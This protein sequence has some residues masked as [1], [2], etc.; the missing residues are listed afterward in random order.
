MAFKMKNNSMA[1]MARE[2]GA[3]RPSA[4]KKIVVEG[5]KAAKKAEREAKREARKAAKQEKKDLKAVGGDQ[6]K[7][8]K[9]RAQQ[10]ERDRKRE[11]YRID[12]REALARQGKG[13]S[14]RDE[15]GSTNYVRATRGGTSE[16]EQGAVSR[17]AAM[18]RNPLELKKKTVKKA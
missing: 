12:N 18:A 9:K 8:D 7:L 6:A 1:K 15:D 4:M 3:G 5:S 17:Q 10:A 13:Y 14:T 2:A 11:Q 16:V